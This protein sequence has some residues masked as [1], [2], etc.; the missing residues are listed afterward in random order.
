M[1]KRNSASTAAVS[2]R[3]NS[4]SMVSAGARFRPRIQRLKQITPQFADS[5]VLRGGVSEFVNTA[6][7]LLSMGLEEFIASLFGESA[8]LD[9]AHVADRRQSLLREFADVNIQ[10]DLY[11]YRWSYVIR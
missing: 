7:R 5:G 3:V 4:S 6:S 8:C 10:H 9:H 11:S 1:A 2:R